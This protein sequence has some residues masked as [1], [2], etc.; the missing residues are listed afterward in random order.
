[1]ESRKNMRVSF[2]MTAIIEFESML[3]KGEVKDLS[4]NGMFLITKERIPKDKKISITIHLSGT[5]SKLTI[6]I[7]GIVVRQEDTGIAI[8]FLELDLDSFIHL[9]NIVAYNSM[10][11]EKIIKEFVEAMPENSIRD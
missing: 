9:R 11:E 3:I 7:D 2:S 4:T 8:Y 10:D 6:N 5:S 1:M